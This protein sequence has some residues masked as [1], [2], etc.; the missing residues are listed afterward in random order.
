MTALEETSRARY[1]RWV[2]LQRRAVTQTVS[3]DEQRFINSYAQQ[4]ECRIEHEMHAGFGLLV[5]GVAP[6]F[7]PAPAKANARHG[8]A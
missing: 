2:R 3:A 6:E 1:Q 8:R 7:E 4:T 5:D